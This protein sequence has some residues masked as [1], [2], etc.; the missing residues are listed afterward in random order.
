M[1]MPKGVFRTV[2]TS[3]YTSYP[4]WVIFKV[5]FT[6]SESFL[7][8]YRI[9]LYLQRNQKCN[10]S[11]LKIQFLLGMPNETSTLENSQSR[12]RISRVFENESSVWVRGSNEGVLEKN[13][14]IRGKNEGNKFENSRGFS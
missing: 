4:F 6:S 1:N 13:I 12:S 11:K 10:N 2:V 5:I 14:E 9:T 3:A 8:R 7:M